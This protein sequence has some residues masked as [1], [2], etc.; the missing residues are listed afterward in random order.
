MKEVTTGKTGFIAGSF[1]LGPHAGHMM[2]LKE[3]ADNCDYLIVGLHIDPSC[4]RQEKNK[5][6]ESVYERYIKLVGCKYVQKV[7]PYETEAD[8]YLM[9]SNEKPN[10]RFLGEDYRNKD[11]TGKDL[12]GI[13]IHLIDRKHGLSSSGLRERIRGEIKKPTPLFDKAS[14]V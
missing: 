3:C 9:L 2:M 8:L 7:I 14:L 5:P 1:D 4:E 11:Y 6:V 13:A 10:I 12:K